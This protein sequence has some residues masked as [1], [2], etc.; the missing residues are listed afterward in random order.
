MFLPLIGFGIALVASIVLL[1]DEHASLAPDSAYYIEA[2]QGKRV[3]IPF[4]YRWLIPLWA[5]YRDEKFSQWKILTLV[6]ICCQGILLPVYANDWRAV[7][8]VGMLPAV[9]RFQLRH[10]VLVD[11]PAMAVALLGATIWVRSPHD[12]WHVAG[13]ILFAL[14]AGGIRETAPVWMA[15]YAWSPLPLI[16]LIAV[17]PGA[18]RARKVDPQADNL[19]IQHP[20]ETALKFRKGHWLAWQMVCIPWGVLLPI[21]VLHAD[22]KVWVA[23]AVAHLPWIATSDWNR[24]SAWAAPVLAVAA[25]TWQSDLWPLLLLIHVFNP[26]RGA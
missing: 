9:W 15:I 20:F 13:V 4:A 10:P 11:A 14:I 7:V 3:P 12:A 21:A 19:W 2:S 16:G 24:I 1:M 8:L 23:L 5:S 18:L 26:Y 17:I 6:S 22:V 25:L